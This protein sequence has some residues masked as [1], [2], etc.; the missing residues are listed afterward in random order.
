MTLI[1]GVIR[2]HTG[3]LSHD[4][5]IGGGE[6]TGEICLRFDILRKEGASR[7]GDSGVLAPLE[8]L[9]QLPRPWGGIQHRSLAHGLKR[10]LLV[11]CLHIAYHSHSTRTSKPF[12]QD[13]AFIDDGSLKNDASGA[14][15]SA[16]GER[17]LEKDGQEQESMLTS[18]QEPENIRKDIAVSPRCRLSHCPRA[19]PRMSSM[20]A[21]HGKKTRTITKGLGP[22]GKPKQGKMASTH[23]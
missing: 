14:I 11:S 10:F 1:A 13:S 23:L 8:W 2:T 9:V 18:S 16:S 7:E 6:G 4:G 3:S 20:R 5:D 22:N 19:S 21:V 17:E 12:D 15:E